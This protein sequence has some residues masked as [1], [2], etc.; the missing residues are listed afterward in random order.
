MKDYNENWFNW[1]WLWMTIIAGLSFGLW[2]QYQELK[3]LRVPAQ[4]SPCN[5]LTYK[6]WQTYSTKRD[7]ALDKLYGS[8][9]S[10][11]QPLQDTVSKYSKLLGIETLDNYHER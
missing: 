5:C 1:G 6:Q 9:K 8:P 10:K 2:A 3:V 11:R 7:N 4:I